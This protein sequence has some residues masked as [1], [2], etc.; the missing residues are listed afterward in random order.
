MAANKLGSPPLEKLL[1][2]MRPT[3]WF[4]AH[5]HCKFAAIIPHTDPVGSTRF[6]ALDKCLPQRRFLQIIDFPAASGPVTLS[7]DL[8]WLAILCIT[9]HLIEVKPTM[10]Y[11]PGPDSPYRY[12]FTPTDDEKALVLEKMAHNLAVP[13][14]FVRTAEPYNPQQRKN[15]HTKQPNAQ[16]NAQTTTLCERLGIDDPISLVMLSTGMQLNHST[17]RDQT[18]ELDDSNASHN[19]SAA[20]TNSSFNTSAEGATSTLK[21]QRSAF[22]LPAPLNDSSENADCLTTLDGGDATTENP[23]RVDIDDD[24][25]PTSMNSTLSTSFTLVRPNESLDEPNTS[26]SD[27]ATMLTSAVNIESPKSEASE[28]VAN[29]SQPVDE[30]NKEIECE[31]HDCAV[32]HEDTPTEDNELMKHEDTSTEENDLKRGVMPM[33]TNITEFGEGLTKIEDVSPPKKFKRRNQ[34]IYAETDELN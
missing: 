7:Y 28:R 21:K 20:T 30:L 8:E 11:M 31:T 27:M 3:Y 4:S 6:L 24:F 25:E 5:L 22:T 26:L 19:D 15:G 34:A 33:Q 18:A 9:K 14:N 1:A 12:D 10:H 13:S 17:Y 16:L 32:K 2:H 23:D 29:A